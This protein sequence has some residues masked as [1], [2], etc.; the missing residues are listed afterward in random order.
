MLVYVRSNFLGFGKILTKCNKDTSKKKRLKSKKKYASQIYF[1]DSD[2]L[3]LLVDYEINQ[4]LWDTMETQ[5]ALCPLNNKSRNW[6][7]ISKQNYFFYVVNFFFMYFYLVQSIVSLGAISWIISC[8]LTILSAFIC[9][10]D[11]LL[12]IN[13]WISESIQLDNTIQLYNPD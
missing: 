13:T 2:L 3:L 4:F 1:L 7:E 5:K 8:P 10:Q 12:R 6:K 9:Y 11:K